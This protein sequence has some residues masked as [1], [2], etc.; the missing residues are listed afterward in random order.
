MPCGTTQEWKSGVITRKVP[1]PLS[2]QWLVT[3]FTRSWRE[4]WEAEGSPRIRPAQRAGVENSVQNGPWLAGGSPSSSS[5]RSP[6]PAVPR[7]KP[8]S[9]ALHG[10]PAASGLSFTLLLPKEF[11]RGN[12]ERLLE[13]SPSARAD[14]AYSLHPIYPFL[15]CFVLSCVDLPACK[16]STLGHL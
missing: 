14:P 2:L 13:S 3:D 4:R 7:V 5:H 11:G 16:S 8:R 6:W 10:T 9:T 15:M 12:G 1:N